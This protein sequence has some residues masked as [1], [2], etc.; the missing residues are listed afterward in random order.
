MKK[1]WESRPT[2][3]PDGFAIAKSGNVYLALAGPENQ[4]VEIAPDGQEVQ[5]FP[6]VPFSGDNGSPVPF[7]TV[8]SAMFLG[9]RLLVA[10]QSYE[11]GDASH[12]AILDVEAGEEGLGQYV[13]PNAGPPAPATARPKHRHHRRKKHHRRRH[14]HRHH[15]G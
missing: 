12:Q 11:S 13:P 15:R 6:Q 2:D 8:S 9:T 3:A 14:H 5:R 10:N 4:L 1:L 7:D